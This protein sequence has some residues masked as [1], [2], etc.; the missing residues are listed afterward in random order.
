MPLLSLWN[1]LHVRDIA[2]LQHILSKL[3]Q[4]VYKGCDNN[5]EIKIVI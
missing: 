3:A 5:T 1:E 2:E 4:F